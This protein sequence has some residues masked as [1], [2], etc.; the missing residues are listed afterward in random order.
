MLIIL[1]DSSVK[2]LVLLEVLKLVVLKLADPG[3]PDS[4]LK[5]ILADSPTPVAPQNQ[6]INPQTKHPKTKHKKQKLK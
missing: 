1:A 4:F 3:L 2:T 5:L 6:K